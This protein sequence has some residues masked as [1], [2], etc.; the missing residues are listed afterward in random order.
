VAQRQALPNLTGLPDQLKAGVEHLSGH[1][2]DD[3]QVH[4][5]SP[6]PAQLQAHAFAQGTAIHLAPGQ[7]HHLPHEAWHVAQQKQGRVK[8]TTQLKGVGINDD[9]SL[10]REATN[11]GNRAAAHRPPLLAGGPAALV[12]RQVSAPVAQLTRWQWNGRR[13]TNAGASSTDTDPHPHPDDFEFEEELEEGDRYDQQTGQHIRRQHNA[14]ER[15]TRS[16]A[17]QV[18]RTDDDHYTKRGHDTGN[19]DFRGISKKNDNRVVD[20]TPFGIMRHGKGP[21]QPQPFGTFTPEDWAD[22]ESEAP[23]VARGKRRAKKKQPKNIRS[24]YDELAG[25][26]SDSE[27]KDE[28]LEESLAHQSSTGEVEPTSLALSRRELQA[29]TALNSLL[30]V[31][32]SN[33]SRNPTGGKVERA[34]LRYAQQV[35]FKRVFNRRDGAY[36]PAHAKAGGARMGGTGDFRQMRLG[37]TPFPP[38]TLTMLGYMS[39]SSEEEQSSSSSESEVEKPPKKKRKK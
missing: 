38:S 9:N 37:N 31:A 25:I 18:N 5:N 8:P 36:I 13:W 3:V 28:I 33:Q 23:K 35:G 2:L 1:S 16:S 4:Y 10:E 20:E 12:Q 34:A 11:M 14:R 39:S 27:Q 22:D 19:L 17:R 32:E 24:N 26:L 29:A 6:R 21:F 7:Q 30:S 15:V